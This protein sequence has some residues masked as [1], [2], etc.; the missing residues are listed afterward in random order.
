MSMWSQSAPLAIVA[1]QA[2][3]SAAKSEE[4]IDGAI[5]VLGAMMFVDAACEGL[6]GGDVC[7]RGSWEVGEVGK[8][9]ER[10]CREFV[11]VVGYVREYCAYQTYSAVS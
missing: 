7:S 4:R 1:E 11:V 3:P 10:G 8:L 5:I 2:A 6:V 9:D